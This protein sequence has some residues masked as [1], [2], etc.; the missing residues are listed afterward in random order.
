M[1]RRF[2]VDVVAVRAPNGQQ[3]QFAAAWA[4]AIYCRKCR[5]HKVIQALGPLCLLGG[6]RYRLP[7]FSGRWNISTSAAS[8]CARRCRPCS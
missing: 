4:E 6:K 3:E 2:P 8:F 5:I 7:T 1:L